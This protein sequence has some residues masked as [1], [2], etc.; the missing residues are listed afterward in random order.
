VDNSNV[1]VGYN[2][3]SVYGTLLFSE[4]QVQYNSN[5][6]PIQAIGCVNETNSSIMFNFNGDTSNPNLFIYNGTNS[7]TIGEQQIVLAISETNCLSPFQQFIVQSNQACV[8]TVDVYQKV[9]G[10]QLVGYFTAVNSCESDN[11]PSGLEWWIMLLIC[12]GCAIILVVV[13]IIMVCV[14]PVCRQAC[15]PYRDD[16]PE[17]HVALHLTRKSI[18]SL[19]STG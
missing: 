13:L 5:S 15:L 12:A 19:N 3:V 17:Q 6:T 18:T 8:G 14:I 4:S 2:G 7:S 10:S 9:E 1:S 11:S 16:S